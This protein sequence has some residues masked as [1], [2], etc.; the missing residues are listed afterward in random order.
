[1]ED[2]QC[3][4][5]KFSSELLAHPEL[6]SVIDHLQ[7]N[8]DFNINIV[9]YLLWLAKSRF[10]RLIK[11][12]VKLL[13]TQVMLHQ[14]VVTELKYTHALVADLTDTASLRIKH[15]LEEEI[16]K[17]HVM[18]QH[19]LFESRLKNRVMRRSPE[20]QLMDACVSLI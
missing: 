4:F 5:V 11:R 2:I 10:G 13:Q 1:M 7:H 15:L 16:V 9:L 6:N 18:E 3:P 19:L 8:S 20:Q 14:R 17:A 12:D